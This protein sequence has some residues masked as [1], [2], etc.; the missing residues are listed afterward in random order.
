MA[1]RE[2]QKEQGI[3]DFLLPLLLPPRATAPA[4]DDDDDAEEVGAAE[5]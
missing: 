4:N 2:D 3:A 1:I 5:D